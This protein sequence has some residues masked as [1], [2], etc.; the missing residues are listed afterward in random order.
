MWLTRP[1]RCPARSAQTGAWRRGVRVG[2]GALGRGIAGDRPGWAGISPPSSDWLS[3]AGAAIPGKAASRP[4]ILPPPSTTAVYTISLTFSRNRCVCSF[5]ISLGIGAP[6]PE[7]G[8]V[9]L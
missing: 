8:M 4:A 5:I 2:G 1:H 9:R 3:Q 7:T 6:R